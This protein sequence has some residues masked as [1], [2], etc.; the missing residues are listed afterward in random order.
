MAD[1][2]KIKINNIVYNLKDATARAN[3]ATLLGEHALEALHAAAWMDVDQAI[4]E[5]AT[6]LPT[7]AAV[8]SYV[9][10]QIGLIH[11]FD[12]QI[13]AALPTA[14]ADTMY[15]LGLVQ[16]SSAEAGTYVE[17]ITIRSGAGSQ[18]DPYT[19]AWEKIGSTKT[20]LTD[21]LTVNATVAGVAFGN[22]KAITDAELKTALDLK[23][24]SHVDKGEVDIPSQTVTG[25]KA[26]GSFTP[27]LKGALGES[28]ANATITTKIAYT[29]SGT[30]S[31]ADI[32]GTFSAL[33]SVDLEASEQGTFQ[34][35]GT[36][37]KPAITVTPTAGTVKAV[38]SV[39]TLPSFTEGTFTKG[40]FTKGAAVAANTD[41]MKM[42]VASG[43]EIEGDVN[44]ETLIIEP[45][46]TDNVM[47]YDA[48]Y[49]SAD[50]AADVWSAGTL[51]ESED[52]SVLASV[53]AELA[54]T[55]V[56]TGAKYA[57][58]TTSDTALKNAK[59]VGTE[60]ANLIPSEISYQ[61]TNIGTLAVDEVSLTGANALAV[62]NVV[63]PAQNDLEVTPKA[64][65]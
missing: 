37:S 10:S 21:Y 60:Q 42:H 44:A 38:K 19:Y 52:A 41:A 28:A 29:P 31:A 25:L 45:A 11:N 8:K 33:K 43:A 65:A 50:K 39:G 2:S 18:E 30:V 40:S 62:D 4:A 7:N 9:D 32:D 15:I 36:I 26:S 61:K 59:F 27:A 55:P 48:T 12:V 20:D 16:D 14:G 17:Y 34:P 13:Y 23:A 49:V 58:N 24:F 35:A 54:A 46:A 6:G 47:D 51:P 53:A 3:L 56:F 64:S 57:I 63:I 5:G 22:D 1:L